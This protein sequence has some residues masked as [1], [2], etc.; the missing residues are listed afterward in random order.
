[1]GGNPAPT[2][3]AFPSSSE[4][5]PIAQGV[6]GEGA[7]QVIMPQAPPAAPGAPGA[8]PPA[9]TSTPG[10]YYFANMTGAQAQPLT[11]GSIAPNSQYFG[12]GSTVPQGYDLF[13][14]FDPNTGTYS[15]NNTLGGLY[16]F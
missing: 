9:T 8:P 7:R 12:P 11:G 16:Q 14:Y 13:N 5:N 4:P 10:Q 2:G 3:L 15:Q 1:M 6:R